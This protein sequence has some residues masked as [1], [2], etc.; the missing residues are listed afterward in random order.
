MQP[1]GTKIARRVVY[2]GHVQGVGFRYTAVRLA[3]DLPIGGFVRNLPD[4]SVELVAE[5]DAA[6]VAELLHRVERAMAGF[7]RN[8]EVTETAPVGY[9]TFVIRRDPAS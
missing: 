1:E 8:R 2:T 4:G 9:K 3:Q 7:I 5:G 6:D